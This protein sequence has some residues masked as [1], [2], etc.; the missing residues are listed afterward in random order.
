MRKFS[1]NP[2][3]TDPDIKILYKDEYIMVVDKPYWMLSVPGRAP[4]NKDCLIS[5][6]QEE[7]SETLIV[8]RL[9]METT[10][11]MILA[12]SKDYHRAMSI[13]FQ[14]RRVDK[15]Y[16]ADIWGCPDAD[17]GRVELPLRCDWENRPLQIV[18]F[19]QGKN[20]LTD[21]EVLERFSNSTRVLLKPE[22]GRTHQLRVHMA[23]MGHP[24]LGDTMY[25][26]EDALAATPRMHLHACMLS[27]KH[28]AT[29]DFVKF[30]A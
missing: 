25:A 22:T 27:F 23:E 1:D 26:H 30:E 10:G 18:D 6:I 2:F 5:R 4:E 12:L 14:E 9:D 29:G 21:W 7:Y 17:K 19:E 8:H 16:I 3:R 15:E 20:A 28:P 11:L 13:E 24:I